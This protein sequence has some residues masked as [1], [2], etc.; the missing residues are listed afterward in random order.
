MMETWEI[1]CFR[2]WLSHS[3]KYSDKR[4]MLKNTI[5]GTWWI[6]FRI[7][8]IF[9]NIFCIIESA[10]ILFH[11]P[12]WFSSLQLKVTSTRSFVPSFQRK[13]SERGRKMEMIEKLTN[14]M[15]S[16]NMDFPN[17][18]TYSKVSPNPIMMGF[19]RSAL[20]IRSQWIN[21][22]KTLDFG[23]FMLCIVGNSTFRNTLFAS[24]LSI[25]S[26]RKVYNLGNYQLWHMS[27]ISSHNKAFHYKA[28]HHNRGKW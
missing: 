17:K 16:N 22:G 20:S 26:A 9:W 10:E 23:R 18:A 28:D 14:M 6:R 19:W 15:Q 12:L 13:R 25:R 2:K 24:W 27:E 7:H 8:R 4:R 21:K 5:S 3:C 11:H 1:T